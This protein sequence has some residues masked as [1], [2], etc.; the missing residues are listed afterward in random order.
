M[1]LNLCF[2]KIH[3]QLHSCKQI[4]LRQL[5]S[6]KR[7]EIAITAKL[8]AAVAAAAAAK[9]SEKESGK[10]ST[11]VLAEDKE[12]S[13]RIA[14]EEILEGDEILKQRE[15]DNRK[16]DRIQEDRDKLTENTPEVRQE[17]CTIIL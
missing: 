12:C 9:E 2:R 3:F 4:E 13:K 10:E 11:N 17:V 5:A 1:S 8:A 16:K 7:E 14:T 15:E 6:K